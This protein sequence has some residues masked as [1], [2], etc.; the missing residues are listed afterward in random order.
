LANWANNITKLALI[1]ELD[2]RWSAS[3]SLRVYL[4]FP[5]AK[6]LADWNG[7]QSSPRG[8]ALADSGYDTA[9]GRS[10]LWNAGLEYRPTKRLTV[11]LDA[12][13]IMGWFDKTLNKRIYYFRGSDYSVEAA[14]VAI[15]ARIAL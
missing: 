9:Y 8:Y 1:H 14:S 3:T 10:I 12:F 4:G 2:A 6:D 5:G 13:N 11:R 7:A 15:S